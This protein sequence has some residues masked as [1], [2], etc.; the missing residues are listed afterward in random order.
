LE[1]QDGDTDEEKSRK[2]EAKSR[3]SRVPL[4]GEEILVLIN[5]AVNLHTRAIEQNKEYRFLT[6][7]LFSLLPTALGGFLVWLGK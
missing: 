3:I 5:T 6:P 1:Y 7:L 4:T 2:T